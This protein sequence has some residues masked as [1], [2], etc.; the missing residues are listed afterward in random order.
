[1]FDA[2]QTL[3]LSQVDQRGVGLEIGAS[4]S[5]VAPKASGLNIRVADYIGQ[6]ELRKK[7]Q[8]AAGVDISRIEPVDYVLGSRT[9]GEVIEEKSQFD[10]IIASHVIEHVPDLLGFVLDCQALLKPAGVLA[11]AV[12]DKRACFDFLLPL[13][14]TGQVL[15][16]HRSRDRQP[17]PGAVFDFEANR[18]ELD[19][20]FAWPLGSKGSVALAG[21]VDHALGM[22][23]R[24]GS[25]YIDVHIWRFVP[26]SFKLLMRDLHAVASVE[27]REKAFL[28]TSDIEFYCFLSRQGQGPAE[29]RTQLA[30]QALKEQS[31]VLG[32]VQ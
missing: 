8:T 1:M 13:S 24:S 22:A 27:L 32:A 12:P 4:Y 18:C 3:L 16:A 26:S 10:Y 7:Y 15:Q 30:L 21:S 6:E 2:R 5:P 25:E 28:T 11:L 23:E 31:A 17:G 29:D 14:T 9:L 20:R 19:G